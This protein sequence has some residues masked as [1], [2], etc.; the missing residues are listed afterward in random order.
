L[1]SVAGLR[2][3]IVGGG[4]SGAAAARLLR[5]RGARPL[6]TDAR[7]TCEEQAAL[8]SIGIE[9]ELGGHRADTLRTADL[10]VLSPGVPWAAPVFAEARRLG[11]PMLG[12]LELASRWFEGRIVAVTGTKGKSTTTT[13]IGD[14][15]HAGGIRALVGGNL[16]PPASGQVAETSP[17]TLHVLEVS[18]FQLEGTDTFHP[19]IA[20]F[21]NFTP[22]HL[23]RH[24]SVEEY[25]QAKGRVFVNQQAED[26]A[27]LNAEDAAVLDLA[28]RTRARRRLFATASVPEGGVG[29]REGHIVRRADGEERRLVPVSSVRVVGRH[30]LADVVAAAA[31][32]DACGV[33]PDAMRRAVEAFSGL[34][35]AM[36]WVATIGGVR[37][38][39]DSK[40]T[41]VD[42]ARRS[43]EAFDGDLV[44]IMGGRFKGGDLGTLVEPLAARARA[45][46]AIG[47]SRERLREALGHAVDVVSATSMAEAVEIAWRRAQP[48][49]TVV[50]APACASF[51]MFRD[52]ADRGR[53]F[54]DVVRRLEHAAL[55]RE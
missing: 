1:F 14:M 49:G 16:G 28:A 50:L 30:L 52:Y 4:R 26:L 13:L 34:E 40:A 5:A 37:F 19:S 55:S 9:F 12:E 22:D 3:V 41:N 29:I 46:V 36:E 25:A 11:V 42:A 33:A 24:R 7:E 2:V 31:V 44:P 23:D 8:A 21:L 20:V 32:A 27:I 45:V 54:K 18:S 6:I 35:H 51:D 10:I 48:S 43:I 38:V 53:A 17:E 15:L 47:E 39:N